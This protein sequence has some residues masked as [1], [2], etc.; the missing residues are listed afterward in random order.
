MQSIDKWFA[1][2]IERLVLG[3][4]IVTNP[5]LVKEAIKKYPG[6]IVLGVD[7]IDNNLAIEGWAKKTDI[8]AEK[9]A[10]DF[11]NFDVASFLCT[12]IERDGAMKGIDINFILKTIKILKKPVIASGG[13]TS[14]NDLHALKENEKKGIEGVVCGRALYENKIDIVEAN[15]I[16]DES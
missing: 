10:K 6:K 5:I 15:Q 14:M 7:L 9:I 8:Q 13:V 4:L 11:E 2:G 12:N 16:L 1:S 3:S